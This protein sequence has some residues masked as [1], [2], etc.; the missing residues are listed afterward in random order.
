MKTLY[1]DAST[2][3]LYVSFMRA[4]KNSEVWA[5]AKRPFGESVECGEGRA[6]RMQ[7][8]VKDFESR[9]HRSVPTRGSGLPDRRQM[10]AWTLNIPLYKTSSLDFLAS[11]YFRRDR[12]YAISTRAKKSHVYGKT[13]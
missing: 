3:L 12:I 7:S 11:G 9:R 13:A 6:G 1:L 8:E 5:R 4:R 2:S 10:F